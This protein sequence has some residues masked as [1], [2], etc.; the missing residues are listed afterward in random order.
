M[1]YRGDIFIL[2]ESL[3]EVCNLIFRLSP[4]KAALYYAGG[5]VN[6]YRQLERRGFDPFRVIVAPER[7]RLRVDFKAFRGIRVLNARFYE[8]AVHAREREKRKFI[9][10]ALNLA[11]KVDFTRER[12][13]DAVAGKGQI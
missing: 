5:I 7:R 11:L 6:R 10:P 4:R 13:A 8:H 9:A 3:P 1:V 2:R 12:R